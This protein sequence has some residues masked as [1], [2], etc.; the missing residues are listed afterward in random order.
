MALGEAA[1]SPGVISLG[2]LVK[3]FTR[4]YRP[5]RHPSCEGSREAKAGLSRNDGWTEK[6]FVYNFRRMNF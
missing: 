6:L 3:K 5:E 2:K 4:K 1:L